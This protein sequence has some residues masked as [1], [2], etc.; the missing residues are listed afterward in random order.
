MKNFGKINTDFDIAT[1]EYV[2][3][4]VNSGGYNTTDTVISL[5]T[6]KRNV[7]VSIPSEARSQ[8]LSLYENLSTGEELFVYIKSLT[9]GINIMIPIEI[10]GYPVSY[11]GYYKSDENTIAIPLTYSEVRSGLDITITRT[12][13][14]LHIF[15]DGSMY[16]V[17]R[18]IVYNNSRSGRE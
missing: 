2:D 3:S 9:D 11:C 16:Y 10:G 6:D 17:D 8:T 14:T 13:L 7:I 12:T 18:F 15:F 1:K 4:C 5:P